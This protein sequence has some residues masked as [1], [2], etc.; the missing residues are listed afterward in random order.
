MSS[1]NLVRLGGVAAVVTG[2]TWVVLVLVSPHQEVGISFFS[3]P[4]ASVLFFVALLGQLAALGGLHA[5]QRERHG[6]L[7]ATGSLIALLG[8]ALQ[9]ILIVATSLL[10]D[11]F[12]SSPLGLIVFV[13]LVLVAL[14]APLV[15]LV[16]LGVAILRQRVLPGWFG[17]LLV[18]GLPVAVLLG[19]ILGPLAWWIAYG[20]FWVLIGYVLLSSRGTMVTNQAVY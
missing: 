20:V 19:V 3:G 2:L 4:L 11:E 5:L 8:F 15:G 7:G 6:R 18:V 1:S 9:V 10:G 13:V 14:L 16:L 12:V 17:V